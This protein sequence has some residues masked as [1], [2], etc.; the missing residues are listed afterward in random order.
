[1][2]IFKPFF[3]KSL[4]TIS[5]FLFA[6]ILFSCQQK[7]QHVDSI[8]QEDINSMK[9]NHLI[10]L[11]DAVKSYKRYDKD[12]VKILKDTLEKKYKDPKF[13]DT[14]MVWFDI[15]DVRAYLKYLENNTS[16]AEGLAFYFAVNSD[17]G[18]QKNQQSFFIAPTI[19]NV[20]NGDTIQSGYTV[21]K[22]GRVFLYEK[23]KSV[24]NNNPQKASFL[25]LMQDDDGYLFNHG[26]ENPP[27]PDN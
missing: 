26:T 20:V 24:E 7:Q 14:R 1:M 25:N 18:N 27:F 12:R 9:E 11:S 6:T 22:G 13:K 16:E 3:T 5:V 17:K 10:S 21:E 4:I 19:S 15:K 2:K 23:Y 8:T